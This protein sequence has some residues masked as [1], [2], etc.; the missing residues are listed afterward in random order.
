MGKKRKLTSRKAV[1]TTFY[2]TCQDYISDAEQDRRAG[3]LTENHLRVAAQQC[4]RLGAKAQ[5]Y[6]GKK[7]RNG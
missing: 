4:F 7:R 1:T 6:G 2:R 3:R 5:R